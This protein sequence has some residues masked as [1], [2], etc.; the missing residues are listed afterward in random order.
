MTFKASVNIKFDFGKKE[1]FERYIP[2][3]SHAEVIRGLLKGFNGTGSRAHIV[4]GPYGTGK[5]L[6][7][8]L[9]SSIVS[10]VVENEAFN[11]LVEKFNQVDDEIYRELDRVRKH[12]RIYLPVILNGYEGTFRK[13]V[14]SAVVRTIKENKNLIVVSGIVGKKFSNLAMWEEKYPKT[15]QHFLNLVR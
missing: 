13:A 5:S 9:I 7:G 14:L 2:T 8:T 10:K 4:V 12:K 3:P 6:I 1:F 11:A 15:Y